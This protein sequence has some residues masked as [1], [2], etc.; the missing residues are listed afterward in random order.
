MGKMK[1]HIK[2]ILA[3]GILIVGVLIYVFIRVGITFNLTKVMPEYATQ[4]YSKA[5]MLYY[6]LNTIKSANNQLN[7]QIDKIRNDIYQEKDYYEK[8]LREI[9][10]LNEK[11][12]SEYVASFS[13]IKKKQYDNLKKTDN[14]DYIKYK[15]FDYK[16]SKRQNSL[17]LYLYPMTAIDNDLYY[18]LDA[19]F[20][21]PIT[22]NKKDVSELK[23]GDKYNLE[24]PIATSSEVIE[25][26]YNGDKKFKY[27]YELD[28]LTEDEK[29]EKQTISQELVL[30][31]LNK[32]EYA[33]YD[34][35]AQRLEVFDSSGKV[36][37]LKDAMYGIIDGPNFLYLANY[38]LVSESRNIQYGDMMR[39]GDFM[40][41]VLSKVSTESNAKI[42]IDDNR[43]IER[44]FSSIYANYVVYDN[45][46][47]ITDLYSFTGN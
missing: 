8:G 34:G 1:K 28:F 15:K 22:I 43:D 37:I 29:I 39:F 4:I 18:E 2:G 41:G 14:I 33:I 12:L 11:N 30:K 7:K 32:N 45:K 13:D 31:D 42:N 27:E 6:D 16:D 25:F 10:V 35:N 20:Y 26:I 24:Y 46:G 23:V 17:S 38:I 19:D 3:Y 40:S 36:D 5:N 21:K 44:L 9:L 47:Y